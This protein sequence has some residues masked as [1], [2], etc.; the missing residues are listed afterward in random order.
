MLTD[1][2]TYQ[3][4]Q[5]KRTL[6]KQ[7]RYICGDCAAECSYGMRDNPGVDCDKLSEVIC[8]LAKLQTESLCTDYFQFRQITL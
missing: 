4:W 5:T 7:I 3:L 2:Y 6:K 8:G 1:K